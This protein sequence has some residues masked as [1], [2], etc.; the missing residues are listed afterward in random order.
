MVSGC[1]RETKGEVRTQREVSNGQ[2]VLQ[3]F[4]NSI[5]QTWWDRRHCTDQCTISVHGF[6]EEELLVETICG[7]KRD[8]KG[9]NS[10]T[11]LGKEGDKGNEQVPGGGGRRTG[12]SPWRCCSSAAVPM[13][14][15][16][17]CCC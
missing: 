15:E 6:D 13:D 9:E 17:S 1:K 16:S 5:L 2:Q 3:I 4:Y 7:C 12:R 14:M 8:T 10:E 11:G